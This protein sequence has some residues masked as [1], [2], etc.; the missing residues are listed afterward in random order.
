MEEATAMLPDLKVL[1]MSA[2]QDV[3]PGASGRRLQVPVLRKPFETLELDR[4]LR[5]VS[6]DGGCGG[7]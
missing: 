5:R 4:L 6:L 1:L 2:Y 3:D 7:D